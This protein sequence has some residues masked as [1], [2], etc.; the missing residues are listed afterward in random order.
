[1]FFATLISGEIIN[2]I[3]EIIPEWIMHGLSVAGGIMPAMGFALTLMVIGKG[4]LFP[5]FFLGF[6]AVQYLGINTMFAAILGGCISILSI[7]LK[8]KE[9][10]IA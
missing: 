10:R 5:F 4:S 1:V 6:F 9:G 2:R 7:T 3:L 8:N